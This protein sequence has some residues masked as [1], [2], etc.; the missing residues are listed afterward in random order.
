[1]KKFQKIKF[2]LQNITTMIDRIPPGDLDF[3]EV[4]FLDESLQQ[5]EVI[6][7]AMQE[8][9]TKDGDLVKQFNQKR[10]ENELKAEIFIQKLRS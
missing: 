7:E 3:D 6:K 2:I 5:V 1:M 10:E 4:G 9:L 8:R